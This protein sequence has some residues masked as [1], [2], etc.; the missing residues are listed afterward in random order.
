MAAL[1][2]TVSIDELETVGLDF[3]LLSF[4]FVLINVQFVAGFVFA[5]ILLIVA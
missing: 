4:V 1:L 3:R 5:F 2:S